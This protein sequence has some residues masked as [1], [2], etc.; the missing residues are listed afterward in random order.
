MQLEVEL[1][2]NQKS[3]RKKI[4]KEAKNIEEEETEGSD[5]SM[6]TPYDEET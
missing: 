2:L 6:E 5:C 1:L 4:V 3:R